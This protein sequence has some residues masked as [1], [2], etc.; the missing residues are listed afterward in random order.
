MGK[1]SSFFVII[2]LLNPL[3]CNSQGEWNNWYFGWHASM[4]FISGQP[5]ALPANPMGQG[6]NTIGTSVSD[7]SGNLLFYSDG[8]KVYCRNNTVMPNG[9]GLLGGTHECQSVMGIP[10]VGNSHQYYL[11]TVGSDPVLYQQPT[12]LHYSI[13]DMQLNGGMGDIIPTQKNISLPFGDSA[14]IQLT[15]TRHKN[16]KDI[17]VVVLSHTKNEKYLSYLVNSS[18][19]SVNPVFSPSSL[20]RNLSSLTSFSYSMKISMDGTN[21]ICTDSLSEVCYFNTSTGVVSSRFK[22][23]TTYPGFNIKMIGKEFSVDAKCLY[24]TGTGANPS[25]TIFFQYNMESTDSLSFIQSQQLIGCCSGNNI[26]LGPDWRIYMGN[27]DAFSDSLCRINNPSIIGM[28]CNYEKNVFSLNGNWHNNCFPQFLQKY[29][30][31]I[32]QIGHCQK[33]SISFSGDIWP[34]A[35]SIHWDF[36]DPAS[37]TANF[38]NLVNPSHIYSNIGNYTIELFVRHNDNRT[39]TSWQTI[40]IVPSPQVAVGPDRTICSGDSTTFDAGACSGCSYLWKDLGSGLIVGT[41]QT[42]RTGQAGIYMVMVTNSNGC[43]GRDTV[44]LFTSTVPT[45]MNN[46]LS[47]SICSGESTNIPLSSN[48]SGTMFHWTT[49]LTSGNISGF[50]PDSG[51]VINQTLVNHLA[52][53]GI[54]TYHVTPKVGSCSGSPVDFAVTVN[55]GDSAKVSI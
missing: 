11:F 10:A 38:S 54:V 44:Q 20:K 51:L 27:Y 55:P 32:H 26:Q 34:P 47:K 4:T 53:P 24:I 36:G 9:T 23:K 16:N 6:G 50:S 43:T 46:P 18:G 49:T 2:I 17:W 31:Y 8:L 33:D 39:D 42:F 5:Y 7:S 37:G 41:S 12:G 14:V 52:T 21:L 22:F 45:V 28:G 29:K 1:I 35:D 25:T 30:A 3:I 13:I 48:V 19:I 15:A 40:T